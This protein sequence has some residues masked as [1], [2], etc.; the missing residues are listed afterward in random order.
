LEII[1]I[2]YN[3]IY[4]LGRKKFSREISIVFDARSKV[5]FSSQEDSSRDHF[6]R[7]QIPHIRAMVCTSIF[8]LAIDQDYQEERR[9]FGLS[10]APPHYF[11]GKAFILF[12][13]ISAKHLLPFKH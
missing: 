10:E 3:I 4:N 6:R 2:K 7:A 11:F 9:L 5:Q 12:I 13:F 1:D 8:K